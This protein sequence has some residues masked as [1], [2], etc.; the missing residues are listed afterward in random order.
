MKKESVFN[1]AKAWESSARFFA[2]N[3]DYYQSLLDRIRKSIGQEAFTA[4]DS[5]VGLDVLRAKL[6][7]L[8]KELIRDNKKLKREIKKMSKT[9]IKTKY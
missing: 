5:V 7:Q 4:D 2:K 8:V 9:S 3:S 1:N 6:P